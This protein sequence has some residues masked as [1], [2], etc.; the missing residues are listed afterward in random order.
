MKRR[1]EVTSPLPACTENV[2]SKKTTT[3][4]Q[5]LTN[6]AAP[7]D[8]YVLWIALVLAAAGVVAVYS[9]ISFLAETKAGGDTERF[10]L[11]HVVRLSLAL[12]AVAVFS[13]IDYRTLA[14]WGRAALIGSLVLL[15]LVQLFGVTQGGATR[16]LRLGP[17]S[18]Q[19]SDLAK[20]ALV[21]YVGVL[22]ARKQEYVKSFSRAFAPIFLWVFLSIVLIG[23]EDLST[24]ALV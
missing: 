22:L 18:I 4:W 1:G 14:R 21:L 12:S 11:R 15:V 3:I 19:P 17:L 9:A 5:R 2:R 24:A 16:A 20:V 10:L 6:P 13:V 8:K 7:A 23:S